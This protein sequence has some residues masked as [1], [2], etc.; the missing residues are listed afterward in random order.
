M[1]SPRRAAAYARTMATSVAPFYEGWHQ[2]NDRLVETIGSLSADE[3]AWS[4]APAMWP[5]WALAGHLAGARVYWL[6]SILGEPGRSATPF[7][8]PGDE[9]WEDDLSRPRETGELVD[10]LRSTWDVIAGCLERWTP[11]MLP[12]EFQRER[13]DVIQLHTRQSI[14]FR[15]LTHD[16]SHAGEISQ[17]LGSHG[18][19]EIELWSRLSR[20]KP[21]TT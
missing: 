4:S 10:A 14:L 17:I 7:R 16:A 9:G 19:G 5:I 6:C 15:L 11:D 12:V 20:V 3:L 1:P 18:R 8:G 2:L 21:K 13:G